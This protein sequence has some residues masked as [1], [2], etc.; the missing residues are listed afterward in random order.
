MGGGDNDIPETEE[1]RELARVGIDKWNDYADNYVPLENEFIR[2]IEVT[3]QERIQHQGAVTAGVNSAFNDARTNVIEQTT[4]SGA[5]PGSGR[6]DAALE[7][8]MKK[9][10]R[11]LGYANTDANNDMNEQQVRGLESAISIGRG[12]EA[13]SMRGM[14]ELASDAHQQAVN[15][16]ETA[17]TRR[18]GNSHAIGVGIGAMYSHNNKD[19]GG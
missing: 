7:R 5:K 3:D 15:D 4:N 10:G 1:E 18:E 11:S 8:V 16:A 17:A 13:D 12:K 19:D 14:S 2:R 6:F 9:H